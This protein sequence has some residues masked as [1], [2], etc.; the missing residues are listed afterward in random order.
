[1]DGLKGRSRRPKMSPNATHV[2]VVGKSLYLRHYYH[3]GP[4]KIAT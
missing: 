2:D 3:L 4:A 1:L